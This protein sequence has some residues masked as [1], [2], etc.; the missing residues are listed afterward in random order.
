M[1]FTRKSS[2][3]SS[4][5]ID[6]T[7]R[8]YIALE[9]QKE[10]ARRDF[11]YFCHLL[12]PRDY[13]EDRPH[14]VKLCKTIQEFYES[15][16]DVLVVNIPPRHYKTRTGNLFAPWV[17]G[18]NP[19]EKIITGSYNEILSMNSSRAARGTITETKADSDRVIYSDIFPGVR[20]KQGEAAAQLWSLE[21][22]FNSY[23]ATSPGGTTTGFG[24]TL[25]IIDDLIRS[26]EEANNENV[27]LK[28][29]IWFT[30]TMLSRL[31]EG[32]KIII[33]MTRWHSEDLAGFVLNFCREN[34]WKYRHISMKARQDDG[35]ML[36][37][38]ILSR[39][40]YDKKTAAMS[41]EIASANYQQ[42]PIDIKGKLYSGFKTY[43]KIPVDATGY[44][45][46]TGIYSYTDTADEG[47]DYLASF[48][49][50]D[51]NGEAY[52]LDVLYTQEPNEVTEELL[53][54]KL[55][56]NQVNLARVESNNGG[57]AFARNV[58]RI[59]ETVLKSRRTVLRW[60]HQSKNK[61][62]R[63]ISHAPWVLEH[64]YFP[65]NW[66]VRWP[67]LYRDLNK[68]QRAGKNTYDDAPD[69]LTG[70]AETMQ[71]FYKR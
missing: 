51:Y 16:D 11:F 46:F 19:K 65:Q 43:D 33:I 14:L 36:C 49:W 10:L 18:R 1:N 26:A 29:Q 54:K 25:M 42:I 35:T 64:V 38:D 67:E 13:R 12:H 37:E 15:N 53:A 3:K 40:S 47:R 9:A 8:A 57:K 41:E 22:G 39:E 44:P 4:A 7:A 60:F 28:H 27:L 45:L 17:F 2:M 66:K 52:I 32:G 71:G 6:A 50:G 34:A 56:E 63:I 48:V 20:L 21:G 58:R 61:I 70:V 24:A 68:Y 5:K 59:L 69:A 30:D 62:A 31:E 23:L 55:Y